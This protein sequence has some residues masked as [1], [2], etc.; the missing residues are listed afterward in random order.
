MALL[1]LTGGA[2]SG[3]SA[4]A[5]RLAS[6]QSAPVVFLAT[7]QPGDEAMEARIAQHRRERPGSWRTIEEPL[8]L[9]EAI[10]GV[11]GGHCMIVDCL[12]LWTAN[13][14]DRFGAEDAEAR[15]TAAAAAASAR[16]GA[17]IAV[18]NEV[19]LGLVPDNLLGRSYRDLLGRVN[20]IWAAAAERALLLVAGRALD[21]E[22]AESLAE[23]LR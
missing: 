7:A 8:H 12:T 6:E 14:L 21:L 1:L 3:K 10:E 18:T 19:G 17:T 11:D 20:A 16:R 23:G 15:A 13:A 9:R 2:R 4:L 5:V 22:R